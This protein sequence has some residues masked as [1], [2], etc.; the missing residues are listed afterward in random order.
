MDQ[1]FIIWL[2]GHS[3]IYMFFSF[4]VFHLWIN[5]CVFECFTCWSSARI[6]VYI[7]SE[8]FLFRIKR[9]RRYNDAHDAATFHSIRFFFILFLIRWLA[10][11][12]IK[13]EPKIKMYVY[14]VFNSLYMVEICNL[15]DIKK[16]QYKSI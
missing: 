7:V 3:F 8:F 10:E 5:D 11:N 4:F 9:W 2:C 6:S 14:I 16:F 12:I 15:D 1:C 13:R